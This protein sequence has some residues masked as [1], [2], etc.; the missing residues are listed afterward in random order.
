MCYGQGMQF[1]KVYGSEAHEESETS[2]APFPQA[3][4][5]KP[6]PWLVWCESQVCAVQ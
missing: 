5:S 1:C 6:L 2:F 3:L 4:G